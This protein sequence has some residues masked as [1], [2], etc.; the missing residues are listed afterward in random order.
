MSLYVAGTNLAAWELCIIIV[1]HSLW[2]TPSAKQA[3]CMKF[4]N[5]A[6]SDFK[7]KQ[8]ALFL[9]KESVHMIL[10]YY[11]FQMLTANRYTIDFYR[12]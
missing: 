6:F 8:A 12:Q 4:M 3:F 1:V 2:L 9:V 5:N 11:L 10:I 7:F